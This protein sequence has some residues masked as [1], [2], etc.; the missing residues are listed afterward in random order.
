MNTTLTQNN[1]ALVRRFAEQG[2]GLADLAAF[3]ATVSRDVVVETGLS[4]AGPIVGLDAYKQIFSG[5]ADAWP[6]TRF[7]ID[8]LWGLDHQVVLRFTAT[9]IFAKDYYG[10]KATRQIIDM[11]EVHLLTVKDGKIIRNIVSGTNFP[12]EYIMY[13]VLKDMVLGKLEVAP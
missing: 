8:E 9:A 13:P 5:F 11:R 4:P 7:V 2:L 6:V 10:M 3:D 12:F 1:V